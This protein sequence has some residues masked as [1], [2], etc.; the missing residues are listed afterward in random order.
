MDLI[1]EIIQGAFAVDSFWS[2]ALRGFVWLCVALAI[3]ANVD[4]AGEN[5]NS[6]KL[7]AN[8]GFLMIFL[9]LSS[10]LIYLLFGVG[11]S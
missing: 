3:I 11:V 5:L 8:L 9:V 4:S 2:V 7:K 1:T 6:K 10:G